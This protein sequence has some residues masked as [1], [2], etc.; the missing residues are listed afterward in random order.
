MEIVQTNKEASKQAD[1]GTDREKQ[2]IEI[3]SMKDE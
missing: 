1:A 2:K 3:N